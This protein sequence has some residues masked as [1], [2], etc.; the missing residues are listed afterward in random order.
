MGYGFTFELGEGSTVLAGVIVDGKTGC[1]MPLHVQSQPDTVA[2]E[3]FAR[4]RYNNLRNVVLEDGHSLPTVMP[5]AWRA[6]F[7]ECALMALGSNLI[8]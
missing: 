8:V 6:G 4:A 2:L 1:K 7:L 3:D 5:D